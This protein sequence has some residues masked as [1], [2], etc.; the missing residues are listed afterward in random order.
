MVNIKN[1]TPNVLKDGTAF[2]NWREELE[3]WAGLK[4]KGLQEILKMIGGR[5]HWSDELQEE[6]DKKLFALDYLD[7]K[8]E[9]ESG[10]FEVYPVH[11]FENDFDGD[12]FEMASIVTC[13]DRTRLYFQA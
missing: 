13:F 8:D 6:V 9:I 4:V 12:D 2:R 3:R 10:D 11:S 7:D 5:K 1:M